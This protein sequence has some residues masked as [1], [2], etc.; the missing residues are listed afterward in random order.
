[1][2]Y[3]AITD[4]ADLAGGEGPFDFKFVP[5][6][7]QTF[8]KEELAPKAAGKISRPIE[9][10]FLAAFVIGCLTAVGILLGGV[11]LAMILDNKLDLAS[12]ITGKWVEGCVKDWIA[13]KLTL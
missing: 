10:I 5:Q 7:H 3:K 8:G 2:L 11:K 6:L 12:W 13:G 1:L 9:N 4:H